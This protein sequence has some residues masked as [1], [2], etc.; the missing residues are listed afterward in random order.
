MNR[1]R[2]RVHRARVER[3]LPVQAQ[4]RREALPEDF[5]H[6]TMAAVRCANARAQQHAAPTPRRHHFWTNALA[7]ASLALLVGLMAYVL[8]P[9]SAPLVN[10]SAIAE[11]PESTEP[12]ESPRPIGAAFT[13]RM[14]SLSADVV[15]PFR[16]EAD[17]LIE[18]GREVRA[19]MLATLPVRPRAWTDEADS[20]PAR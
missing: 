8:M 16:E 11:A 5:T 20:E 1:H 2:S 9:R 13:P 15:M 4:A 10:D 12:A 7:L 19:A 6:R 3:L 17:A 14:V 18:T